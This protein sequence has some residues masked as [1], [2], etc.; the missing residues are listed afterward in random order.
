MNK[1]I[2]IIVV[3]VLILTGIYWL[4]TSGPIDSDSP[5]QNSGAPVNLAKEI[6]IDQKGVLGIARG[7]E[8]DYLVDRDGM[9][10]YV[11]GAD[12]KQTGTSVKTSCNTACEASWPPY[13]VTETDTGITE[14]NDA[15]LSKLNV[16]TRA[17]G[18]KQYA[19][20]NQPLY[21]YTMDTVLGDMNGRTVEDW[22]V[23]KP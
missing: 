10:L 14:S 15:L 11:K 23:A 5:T 1:R 22:T 20:G 21:R 17:D 4:S 16:I 19:L 8:G 6:K 18:G 7:A 12:A 3:V 2:S 13:L 9:T